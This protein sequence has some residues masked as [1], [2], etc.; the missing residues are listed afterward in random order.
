MHGLYAKHGSDSTPLHHRWWAD[1]RLAALYSQNSGVDA[2]YYDIKTGS[3][4]K[5][6]APSKS[7]IKSLSSTDGYIGNGE[8]QDIT[9]T[10]AAGDDLYAGELTNYLTV[11]TNDPLTPSANIALKA[12]ITGTNLK[13]EAGVD[14]TEVDFGKVFRTSQQNLQQDFLLEI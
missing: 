9:V 10:L 13:A 11:V 3:A 1:T 7:M 8:S 2:P 5:I 14:A 4:I 12:N 6:V